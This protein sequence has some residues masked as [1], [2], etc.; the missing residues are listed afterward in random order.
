MKFNDAPHPIRDMCCIAWTVSLLLCPA[1]SAQETGEMPVP[2][3]DRPS[4]AAPMLLT[5]PDRDAPASDVVSISIDN[6]DITQVLTAFSLQTGRSIVIGPEVTGLV[7][8]RLNDVPWDQALE[9]MLAPYGFGYKSIGE[10]IV[11]NALDKIVEAESVEPLQSRVFRLRYLDATDIKEAIQAQ[12]SARG[13]FSVLSVRGQKGWRFESASGAGANNRRFSGVSA[14]GKL[15]RDIADNESDQVKS[16]VFIVADIRSVLERIDSILDEIDLPPVQ[17]LIEARF[18]EVTENLL[19]DIGV[20]FGTGLTGAEDPG[21]Q[22]Q[23]YRDGSSVFAGGLQSISGT[24]DPSAFEPKSEGLNS[25]TPFNAGMSLMFQQLTDTQFQVLLHLLEEDEDANFLSAPR[26]MTLDNQEATIIVGTKFPIIRSDV[27]GQSGAVSTSLEY[28]ENIGIQLNVVPQVCDTDKVNMIVHPAVTTQIGVV[29]ARAGAGSGDSIPL[30]EYPV[31]DTREAETQ[32]LL[33]N[34]QTVVIGGLL[35]DR[36]KSTVLKVPYMGDIPLLGRLFRRDVIDNNKLD[37][38]IFLTATLMSTD[39]TGLLPTAAEEAATEAQ[40]P[41][42]GP[43]FAEIA[44]APEAVVANTLDGRMQAEAEMQRRTDAARDAD[45]AYMQNIEQ[46]VNE[47]LQ[48]YRSKGRDEP[49]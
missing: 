33:N 36:E 13:H 9:V 8:M 11:V 12:L 42:S 27:T 25:T 21:V 17:I 20:E 19:R 48:R 15:E 5:P 49:Q 29:S 31:L 39:G 41:Q 23:L 3:A 24:V 32:I 46:Q 14:L 26:V 22:S 28:Y 45:R 35:Q 16:K 38:L 47:R 18:V 30:T 2:E 7:T 34:G 1:L 40:A 4:A 43:S 6:A 44:S 37:L 10:T